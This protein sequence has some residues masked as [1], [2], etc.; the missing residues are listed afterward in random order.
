MDG[1]KVEIATDKSASAA[2]HSRHRSRVFGIEVCAAADTP[3]GFPAG[4]LAGNFQS[5]FDSFGGKRKFN[6]TAKLKGRSVWSENRGTAGLLP[7]DEASASSY[8]LRTE[9]S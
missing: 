7:F 3:F 8:C 6:L 2:M 1:L 5:A 4:P 9:Y